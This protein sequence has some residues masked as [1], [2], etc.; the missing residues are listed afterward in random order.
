MDNVIKKCDEGN[1]VFIKYAHFYDTSI[2][3]PID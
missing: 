2:R 1:F 3:L